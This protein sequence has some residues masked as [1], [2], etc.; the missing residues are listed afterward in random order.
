MRSAIPRPTWWSKSSVR[1]PKRQTA[2]S[3]SK[4]TLRMASPNWLLDPEAETVEVYLLDGETYA[5]R[6]KSDHGTLASAAVPGFA[7]PVRAA[8]DD[9]ANL[10]ALRALLAA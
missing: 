2:A 10:D 5:L 7:V 9:A 3:S 6:L 1:A 8:F 4:T